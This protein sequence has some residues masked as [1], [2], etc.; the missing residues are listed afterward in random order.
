MPRV[1]LL[2]SPPSNQKSTYPNQ[3]QNPHSASHFY[4]QN[5]PQPASNRQNLPTPKQ[6]QKPTPLEEVEKR[7]VSHNNQNWK[8]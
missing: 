2:N 5:T 1:I 7:G 6:T 4:L 3:E 8:I